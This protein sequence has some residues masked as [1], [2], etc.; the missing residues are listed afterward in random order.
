MTQRTS[1]DEIEGF[2]DELI[3]NLMAT[4]DEELLAEAIQD[5][6]SVAAAIA[7][8][9]DEIS[10]AINSLAKD[11][12]AETRASLA[13]AKQEPI[14]NRVSAE[15]RKQ[16]AQL[17][18]SR[19]KKIGMTLAARKDH[20]ASEKDILS[21]FTDLC[22]LHDCRHRVPIPHFG[23]LPKAE[24]ILRELGI[25]RPNEIDV[26]AIAWRLGARVKYDRL[27]HCEAR[28]VGA[29]DTA[30]ITVNQKASTERQRFSVCHEIGHWIYH[31]RQMLLCSGDEIERPSAEN[32]NLERVADRFASELLMPAY[33]FAPLA[34]SFGRPSMHVVRKLAEIFTTSQTA[35]AI[36][37]VEM[38]EQPMILTC[39]GRNGRRWF[40]RSRTIKRDWFPT[41][42]LS[43]ETST[44]NMLHRPTPQTMPPRSTSAATWFERWDASR[45]ELVEE[46]F[47][48]AAGEVLTL[49]RFKD[50]G[51]F[52]RNT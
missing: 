32:N 49:L 5:H 37:L 26:E 51:A 36:R 31:R 4:P 17:V 2:L 47:R 52:S 24:F 42:D 23:N 39:Y 43:H 11:R 18:A 7:G 8:I 1:G 12:L 34:E 9:A 10:V 38:N 19:S 48:V 35:T 28:I 44:F 3:E 20:G 45:F 21:A 6:G 27:D 25:T 22:E 33:L 30:I 41:N 13:R 40:A 50:A 46:S 15:A 16:V 14:G 29:N